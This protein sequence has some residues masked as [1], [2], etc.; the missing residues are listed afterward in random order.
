MAAKIKGDLT[1]MAVHVLASRTDACKVVPPVGAVV[2]VPVPRGLG[3]P[4]SFRGA[5]TTSVPSRLHLALPPAAIMFGCPL[6][7]CSGTGWRR[8]FAHTASAPLPSHS[9]AT[10]TFHFP[11]R[12]R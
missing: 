8:H 9:D 12:P 1:L 3:G 5:S 11:S 7:C 4:L 10:L 6:Y 2:V